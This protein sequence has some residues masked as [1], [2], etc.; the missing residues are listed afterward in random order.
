MQAF[1]TGVAQINVVT[2]SH[3]IVAA[4]MV[5]A[6]DTIVTVTPANGTLTI[7][8]DVSGGSVM[9][10]KEGLGTLEMK[11]VRSSGLTV[12]GGTVFVTSNGSFSGASRIT[13][14]PGDLAVDRF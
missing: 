14:L 6:S 4:L 5:L 1:S 9:I 10:D 12:N 2:G 11:N 8:S 3:T 13:T 7:T